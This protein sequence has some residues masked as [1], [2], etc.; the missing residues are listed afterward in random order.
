VLPDLAPVPW[1]VL[2]VGL[3]IAAGIRRARLRLGDAS[4][5]PT[6]GVAAFAM[7]L[8]SWIAEAFDTFLVLWVLG[9]E[10]SFL[11]VISF[12]GLL[13]LVRSLAIFVPAG[14]GVQDVGYLLVLQG[15]GVPGALALGT[16]FLLLKRSRELAL[17]VVGWIGLGREWR[18]LNLTANYS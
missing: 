17:V 12:E 7:F 1:L 6:T 14:L 9:A 16:A 5:P 11:A 10:L 15:L 4:I 3:L 18:A 8:A 2:G 13:S